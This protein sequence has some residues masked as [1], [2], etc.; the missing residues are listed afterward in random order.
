[1][2]VVVVGAGGLGSYLGALL[3]RA[4][5]DVAL[6]ARG[7][8]AAAIR[9]DGLSV[10]SFAGDFVARPSVVDSAPAVGDVEL[11][12]LAVKAFSLDEVAADLAHLASGGAHVVSV[13]NGVDVSERLRT[14]GVPGERLVD[15]IAY[16]TAFRIEPGRVERRARHQRLVVGSYTGAGPEALDLIAEAFDDTGVE[17]EI[18]EDIRAELWR[19]M[20]VVCSLSVVCALSGRSMG[21]IRSHPFGAELQ[22]RAIAEVLDVGRASGVALPPE[23]NPEIGD[24]LDAFP[25]DF[26][27]SVIHDLKGGRRTEMGE[28]G[29]VVVRL[30]R[31]LGVDVPLHEAATLAVQ[32]QEA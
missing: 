19:K 14:L 7:A 23:V 5:H 28:L 27:P 18:A 31:S 6:V 4:G 22:R 2:K 10:D 13:L 11:V 29:G 1:M 24:L 9:R 32:L 15:G 16:M 17:V 30:G 21:P 25:S 3:D 8:H 12:I 20:A 26:H